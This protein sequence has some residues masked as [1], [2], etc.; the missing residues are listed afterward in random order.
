M[1]SSLSLSVLLLFKFELTCKIKKKFPG[2]QLEFWERRGG[3]RWPAWGEGLGVHGE[4]FPENVF[5]LK[6]HVSVVKVVKH[7]KN[8]WFALCV[9]HIKF[10][11]TRL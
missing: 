11:G 10:C 8:L 9:R 5:C 1:T 2:P 3:T 4:G 6:W 7:E